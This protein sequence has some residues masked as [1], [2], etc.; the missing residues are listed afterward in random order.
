M[1]VIIDNIRYLRQRKPSAKR[2]PFH[3]L[4]TEARE[5]K[6]ETLQQVAS[7]IATT[8]S[9]LWELEAGRAR[10]GL[11]I[12]QRLLNYYGLSFNEISLEKK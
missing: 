6:L 10:P 7:N 12:L 11:S 8:K 5:H 3:K 9:Y 4:I 2:K 1:E